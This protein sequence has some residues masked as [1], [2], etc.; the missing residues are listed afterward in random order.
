MCLPVLACAADYMVQHLEIP[1][2]QVQELTQELYYKHGT[3]MAGLAAIGHQLDFDHYHAH[4]HGS[5]DYKNLLSAQPSTRSTLADLA[6]QKHIFTNADVKHTAAC[7]ERMGLT[8]CFQSIW[9]FENLMETARNKGLLNTDH[10]VLCKPNKQAF[11]LVLEQL[12]ASPASTIFIDDSMRNIAAAHELGIFT[13]L[14]SPS[15]AVQQ[16][17]HQQVAGADLVVS[18]FNQL[19]EVLPQVRRTF[20]GKLQKWVPCV[21]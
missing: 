14:V 5:L 15:L 9:C 10:P 3:T 18:G 1:A 17:P 19:R 7:L 8:D 4:V 11:Q 12:G 16:S 6:L 2:S 21:A 13:V 20:S